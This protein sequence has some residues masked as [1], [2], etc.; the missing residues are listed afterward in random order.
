M[1]NKKLA[2]G[3]A[4]T[5][6]FAILS[7]SAFALFTARD[8][9]DFVAKA[10]NVNVEVDDLSMTNPLNINPGDNDPNNPEDAAAGTDHIFE[11]TVTNL[12]NKSIR[13]RHTIM[14]SATDSSE[15]LLDARYLGLYINDEEIISK[16]YVLEDGTEVEELEE[17]EEQMV[18]AIKYVFISDIFDGYGKAISDG[19]DAEKESLAGI[20]KAN[21]DGIVEE[22]YTYDFALL[23]DASNKY[24]NAD[25]HIDVIVE[26]MQYRNTNES[27]WE[28][29]T[30]VSRTFS[31]ADVEGLY[32]PGM[33][34]DA[35]GNPL[36]SEYLNEESTLEGNS[37]TEIP[38]ETITSEESSSEESSDENSTEE[39]SEEITVEET[40]ESE[41]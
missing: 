33:N 35:N 20:I 6:S 21:D 41:D 12:G 4:T 18:K 8:D 13:T 11:Y 22:T 1:K 2:I 19:G 17:D 23:R 36:D 31:T 40:T 39:T 32:V 37:E 16:T 29:V 5:T 14:L 9:S 34:E 26:A 7:L 15:E 30:T 27:D 28:T 38:E 25:F 10:G 24:Q 3:L